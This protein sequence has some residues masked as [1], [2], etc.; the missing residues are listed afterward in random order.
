MTAIDGAP[1]AGLLW[2]PRAPGARGPKPVLSVD[3]IVA[4]ATGIA[5]AEGLAAVSMQRIADELGF[6]K[7]SL[8]RHVPGKADLVAVMTDRAFGEPVDLADGDWRTQL[9]EWC[10]L[11]YAV[12][13]RHP[14]LLDSSLCPRVWGPFELGWVERALAALEGTGLTGA[15]R[16]DAVA[17]L[18]GHLRAIAE[19]AR[20]SATPEADFSR[21]LG[22]LMAEHGERFPA[23]AA[24]VAE[25][26]DG[27][28][29][30]ALAFGLERILD[31]L[32]VLIGERR[33]P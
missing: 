22:A 5:D 6:T 15:E 10:L 2:E 28:Q 12:L 13:E 29:D 1:G 7:M 14:W 21:T 17:T 33:G 18:T 25:A 26:A 11:M 24:A 23:M 8:Y 4:V 9:G 16:L 30:N 3:R 19:Q 31:G 20:N 27:G 32:A